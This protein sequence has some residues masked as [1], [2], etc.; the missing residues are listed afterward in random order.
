MTLFNWI[1]GRLSHRHRALSRYKRGMANA[2]QRDRYAAL[3]DYTAVIDMM[4]APVD[5]RA[6]ALYNRSL[7]YSA[8]QNESEAIGDL[9][10]LL[11]IGAAETNVCIEARRMLVRIQRSSERLK[12]RTANGTA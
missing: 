3:A 8:S 9:K 10:K 1:T 11:E 4:D 6:M 2:R 5:I 12:G 7:V